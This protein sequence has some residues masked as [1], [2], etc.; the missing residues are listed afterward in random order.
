[1]KGPEGH[2]EERRRPPR[3]STRENTSHYEEAIMKKPRFVQWAVLSAIL[4]LLPPASAPVFAQP[5]PE[6]VP[7]GLDQ[8]L[9]TG[10]LGGPTLEFGILTANIGGQD[11]RRPRN[12][13]DPSQFLVPQLYEYVLYHERDGEWVEI[14]RRRKPTICMI[15]DTRRGNVH[16]CIQDHGPVFTCSATNQ[17]ISRGWA[18]DYFRGLNGQWV[19]LGDNTGRFRLDALLDP[20]RD[21][22]RS[23]IPDASRDANPDNN[24][25]RAIFE[26]DGA[27]FT[28]I[29]IILSFDPLC[30]TPPPTIALEP[31]VSGL[32]RPVAITHA[33]DGSGRLF[34]TLQAGQIVIFD[35][36]QILPTPF[37][38]ITDLVIPI[39]G[40]GDERG[41]LSVAFHPNYVTNGYFYVNYV[42]TNNDTVV[43]RYT[44]S[45]DPNVADRKTA[46]V[47][48]TITQPPFFNHKGGQ[49]QFG[50]D[51]YLYIGTGDG[52]SAGDPGNRAQNLGELLG[53]MLRID[54]N[55]GEP[56][57]IPPDNPF[58][59]VPG[60]REEISAYGLRNPWRFSFDRGSGD[61]YIGDVGQNRREEVDY[62]TFGNPGGENYGWRMME[63]SLCFNPAMDCNDGTLVLP[64]LE[65]DRSL[66][67][68]ITGGYVYRG[69]NI[70]AIAGNYLYADYGSGRIWS[71]IRNEDGTWRSVELLDTT[72]SISTF[73]EDEAGEMYLAHLALADGVIYRIV[74]GQ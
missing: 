74:R 66:G 25:T 40:L 7:M 57:A 13:D 36:L 51:T 53:K 70:P 52:G 61:L 43:A 17:G 1:M 65:Y 50:P 48:L 45:A 72:H 19:F 59:G 18:D 62:R 9:V 71:G 44:V 73:G 29:E 10:R 49:L 4:V 34:I 23:D 67:I 42:N 21:L 14:D 30:V 33:G 58:V 26:W 47:V 16:P 64:V 15:D 69:M 27:T 37:L 41:L 2:V 35:G 11:F 60:A 38:D 46:A 54:V 56:Y 22:Q 20:D 3:G 55:G 32:A 28:L 12:P 39:G 68:A 5:L 24:F 6:L 63:G 31:L 8:W